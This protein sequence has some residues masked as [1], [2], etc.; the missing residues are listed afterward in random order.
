M[1][2][3]LTF[4]MRALVILAALMMGMA[5]LTYLGVLQFGVRT[6]VGLEDRSVAYAKEAGSQS[7]LLLFFAY[8]AYCVRAKGRRALQFDD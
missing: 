6:G 7:L 5:A 8:V 2:T 1:D 4:A 3:F